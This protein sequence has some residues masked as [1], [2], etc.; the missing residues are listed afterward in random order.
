M[1]NAEDTIL[2]TL[3]GNGT[4][5]VEGISESVRVIFTTDSSDTGM[6]WVLNWYSKYSYNCIVQT[7]GCMMLIFQIFSGGLC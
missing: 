4:M 3:C 5:M 2:A 7:N 1:D 6:G